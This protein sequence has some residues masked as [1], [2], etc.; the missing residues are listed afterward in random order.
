MSNHELHR[1]ALAVCFGILVVIAIGAYITSQAGAVQPA[2]GGGLHA[3]FHV[4]VAVVVGI[5]TL[6]LAVGQSLSKEGPILGWTAVGFYVADGALGWLGWPVLHAS[7]APVVLAIPVAIAVITSAGWGQEPDPAD[8]GRAP[9]LRPLAIAA[10]PVVAL[11]IVLGAAYRHKVTSV[12]PHMAGAMIAGLATLV[13]AMLVMQQYPQ[14]R[15]MRS[16]AI[17][18]MSIVLTQVTLGVT[19]FTMQLL[20]IQ[21]IAVLNITTA[22]H[23]VVGSLTLA[24]SVVFAM[25]VIRHLRRTQAPGST[26]GPTEVARP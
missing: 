18:L 11:Q 24:A 3:R 15:A 12:M 22:S 13:A 6:G 21:N 5:L 20:E 19:A 14:H 10:P 17:W 25:Q 26:A 8:A 23:V 7:L 4:V 16:A 1:Y 2:A 9:L